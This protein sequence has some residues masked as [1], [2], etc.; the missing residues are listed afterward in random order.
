[1]PSSSLATAPPTWA[2]ARLS[3]H[4]RR[5]QC[6]AAALWPTSAA[7][8]AP[9]RVAAFPLVD[10][11]AQDAAP[12]WAQS[13][14][15]R[16]IGLRVESRPYQ[17]HHTAMNTALATRAALPDVMV[18]EASQLGRFG[19]GSGLQRLDLAP[20][21]TDSL[22]DSLTPYALAQARNERRELI[23]LPADLGP[24]TLLLRQ[25]LL[26]RSG[27]EPQSLSE[28][29][30]RYIAAGERI[31]SRTGA[32]LVAHVQALR[33][34]LQRHGMQA[35]E[36]LYFDAGDRPLLHRPRFR[37]CFELLREVR[38]LNLDARLNTWSN[39]WA[40]ALRRGRLATELGGAWLV[41]QLSAWVAPATAGL[42]RASDLPGGT[43]TSYG[44]AFYAIP[45]GLPAERKQQAWD[46]VRLM[47][48]DPQL[49]QHAF[50]HYDAFPALRAAQQGPFFDEALPF[51][52]GQ[53]ARRLWAAT[54]QRIQAPPPHRQDRFADEV[55]GTELDKVLLRN[56]SID[57]A[58]EDAERL[59]ARRARR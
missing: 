10:R 9:L 22:L 41:G 23:A 1:M 11:I 54:A 15:G 30:E 16:S 47:C 35:G 14:A 50:Q 19:R 25:D 49:Q 5:R 4:L 45:Q 37:R 17:D 3:L 53:A 29:W 52:G 13:T 24:G 58:L 27:L 51:L 34:I 40:E 7:A 59:I 55:M 31:R 28:S 43:T 6:L 48:T 56:K 8:Q 18:L 57:L 38:R 46:F 39:E 33:D 32:Y 2:D 20:F 36:G 44:G 26:D 12:R 42:W 21:A